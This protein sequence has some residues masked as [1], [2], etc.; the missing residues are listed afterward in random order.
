MFEWNPHEE[1]WYP[2]HHPFTAPAGEL[3]PEDPGA[4]MTQAYDMVWNGWEIG[5][6]SIRISDAELQERVLGAARDRGRGGRGALRLPARGAALR[7][8]AARRH[9]LRRRPDRR[10]RARHRLDPRR[11]RLPEDRLR[12]RPADRGARR[13]SMPSSCASSGSPR[14]RRRPRP[15]EAVGTGVAAMSVADLPAEQLVDAGARGDRRPRARAAAAAARRR[16]S[17]SRPSAAGPRGHRG[18]AGLGARRATTTSTGASARAARAA[19]RRICSAAAGSSTC[20]A[21][22]ARSATRPRSSSRFRLGDGAA[23]RARRCTRIA[24]RPPRARRR[25]LTGP[26]PGAPGRAMSSFAQGF[27]PGRPTQ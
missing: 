26:V 3:D 15:P 22:A 25:F 18:G 7:R 2:L 10:A 8:A 13:R 1:R 24:T 14:S 17:R 20:G 9:R 19:R 11:D 6:G 5:G 23:H 16:E 12:R 27:R 21:T 4:A